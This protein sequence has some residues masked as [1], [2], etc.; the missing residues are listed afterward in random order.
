MNRR[1]AKA[2]L[3]EVRAMRAELGRRASPDAPLTLS[4]ATFFKLTGL[5]ADEWDIAERGDVVH[6]WPDGTATTLLPG[7]RD[8]TLSGPG[9]VSPA[10]L[11]AVARAFDQA[12]RRGLH[13]SRTAGGFAARGL[14]KHVRDLEAYSQA[15]EPRKALYAL[16]QALF[17]LSGAPAMIAGDLD[18]RGTLDR[19]GNDLAS[20]GSELVKMGER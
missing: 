7:G 17:V 16:G 4:R 6:V 3:A 20:L 1:Q 18:E 12:A 9:Y 8:V 15:G 2:I 19:V 11:R 5:G 14:D 10:T 13:A